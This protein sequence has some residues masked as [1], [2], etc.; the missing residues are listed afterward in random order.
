LAINP[1]FDPVAAPLAAQQLAD[2]GGN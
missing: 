2:L 1:H